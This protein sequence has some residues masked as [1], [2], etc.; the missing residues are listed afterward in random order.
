MIV[1]SRAVVVVQGPASLRRV[2]GLGGLPAARRRAHPVLPFLAH[3]HRRVPL[4]LLWLPT[5]L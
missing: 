1:S 5:T 4:F 3:R 2:L